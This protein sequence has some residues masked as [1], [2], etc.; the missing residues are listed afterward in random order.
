MRPPSEP[1]GMLSLT[2]LLNSNFV[3]PFGRAVVFFPVLK[4]SM[5]I[6][7]ALAKNALE[8]EARLNRV[9]DRESRLDLIFL[10]GMFV[11]YAGSHRIALLCSISPSPKF[12]IPVFAN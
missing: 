5:R 3:K 8:Q 2:V 7:K 10:E 11:A 9:F 1:A 12:S 4:S 6:P